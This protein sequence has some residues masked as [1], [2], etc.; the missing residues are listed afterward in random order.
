MNKH[1]TWRDILT[2]DLGI[3]VLLAL[4]KLVIHLL[5]N[6]QYGFYRDELGMLDDARHLAWGYVSYPPLTAFLMRISWD[7]FG[8]NLAWFRLFPALAESIIIVLV[9]L[10]AREMGGGRKAQ[11]AAALATAISPIGLF[12]STVFQYTVFECLWWVSICFLMVRL[13]KSENP[14]YWLGIGAMIGL[15]VLTKYS[16]LFYVIGLA[17]GVLLTGRWR[18]LK[19]PWLWAGAGIAALIFLP[20]LIWLM[21]NK[22]IHLQFLGSIHARDIRIGRTDT[23]LI[24]QIFTPANPFTIPLWI[25]GLFFFFRSPIGK[26]YRILGWMAVVPFFILW[27]SQGRGYYTS[28]LYLALFAGGAV[29]AES[30]LARLAPKRAVLIESI[31]WWTWGISGAFLAALVLP[32][33]PV[34]SGWWEFARGAHDPPVE[35]IG[36]Q[37]LVQATAQAWNSL[38]EA[39]RSHAAI[40]ADYAEGG[41]INL[42][43]PAFGLPPVISNDNTGW[44]RGYG[45]PPPETLVLVGWNRLDVDKYF[46]G[47][48]VASKINMPYNVKNEIS[49]D[50]LEIFIC[51]ETRSPWPQL[52]QEIRNFA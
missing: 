44:L 25:A 52:W 22:F 20:N 16:M 28:S 8:Q 39:D 29:L 49:L 47:C 33:A 7:L 9:G 14:R 42:Y 51:T 24:D 23:F 18:W 19:S 1:R 34:G 6:S 40:L 41:A 26:P 48:H 43:G 36:W 21:Q 5:T 38:P 11:L 13:V 27:I 45:D 31:A 46:T 10:I 50:H 30:W 12:W 15:G 32:I 3:L 17:A 37:E 2:S 35:E 4:A